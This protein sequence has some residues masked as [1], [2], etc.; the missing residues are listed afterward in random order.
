MFC[1]R[2]V[3][4]F[5]FSCTQCL[6]LVYTGGGYIEVLD[7]LAEDTMNHAVEEVKA[8]LE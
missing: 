7:K 5:I 6:L 2:N 3:T 4:K 8:S 1:A